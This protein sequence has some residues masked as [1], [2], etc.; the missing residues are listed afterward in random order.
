MRDRAP[1]R[2]CR[3]ILAFLLSLGSAVSPAP[4]ADE[5]T[6]VATP[7]RVVEFGQLETQVRQVRRPNCWTIVLRGKLTNPYAEAVHGA[8]LIVRLRAAGESAREVERFETEVRVTIAPGRSTTFNREF[9]TACSTSFN[10]I[11]VVGFARHRGGVELPVA[12]PEVEIAASEVKE[13]PG[14][15]GHVAPL[16][17]VGTYVGATVI[18]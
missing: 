16:G 9:T 14:N 10:D 15:L 5:A 1:S 18:K 2:S 4:A 11:S 12:S 6:P 8:R 3:L 7:A 13:A 17:N